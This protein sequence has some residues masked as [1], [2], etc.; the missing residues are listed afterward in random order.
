MTNG[1]GTGGADAVLR[2]GL[3]IAICGAGGH[4]KV[5]ADVLSAQFPPVTVK[6]FLDD[7][8]ELH[9]AELCGLPVLGSLA[10][11]L[12]RA[13]KAEFTLIVGIGNNRDRERIADQVSEAGFSFAS[14]IHPSACIGYGV[15]IGSGSVLMANTV[16]NV[17]AVIGEHV[18]INTSASV[19]HDCVVEDFSHISPGV[20]LAGG[21]TVGRGAHIG[22]GACAVPGVRIGEWATVGAG[23]TVVNDVPPY[24]TVVGTPA[25]PIQRR[26]A[27]R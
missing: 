3:A 5:V 15:E 7:R 20:N 21:V 4:A 24:T 8:S 27:V 26:S 2:A 22:I 10:P 6:G 25:A 12:D 19:D 16:V 13:S 9:G 23:A 18:I 14:A 11:W 1:H 17:G